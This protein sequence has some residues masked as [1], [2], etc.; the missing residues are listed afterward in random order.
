MFS[1][2]NIN[3]DF[4]TTYLFPTYFFHNI[5]VRTR[6]ISAP[7]RP[8]SVVTQLSYTVMKHYTTYTI[9]YLKNMITIVNVKNFSILVTILNVFEFKT[10]KP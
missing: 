2:P 5:L 8:S 10:I 1:R 4:L 6:R 3:I 7:I 9:K